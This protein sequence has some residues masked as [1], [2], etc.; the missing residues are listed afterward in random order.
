[1]SRGAAAW[2]IALKPETGQPMQLIGAFGGKPG[3]VTVGPTCRKAA[4]VQIKRGPL[5]QFS[6]LNAANHQFEETC[7]TSSRVVVRLRT[8]LSHGSAVSGDMIVRTGAKLRAL[9]YVT[10]S[11]TTMAIYQTAACHY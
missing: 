3:G 6:L 2:S 10:W 1:V 11:P 8:N 7:D 4:A 9:L 5:A